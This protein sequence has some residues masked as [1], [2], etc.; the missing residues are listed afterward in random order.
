MSFRPSKLLR[1]ELRKPNPPLLDM[2]DVN[3]IRK[4]IGHNQIVNLPKLPKNSN[5]FHDALGDIPMVTN[6]GE[7][8]LLIN[9]EKRNLVCFTTERN[10][11]MLCKMNIIFVDGTFYSCPNPFLQLFT[12]HGLK[13]N[14][15]FPLVYFLLPD[16]KQQTYE[17]AFQSL[18]IKCQELGLIFNPSYVRADFEIAIHAA[19]NKICPYAKNLGCHFHLGQ[20]W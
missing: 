8:F 5:E 1:T 4:N 19:I 2:R 15:Y 9:D 16:K 13:D 3:L 18:K 17:H 14:I 7:N 10:L 11:N 6:K 20:N 12:I